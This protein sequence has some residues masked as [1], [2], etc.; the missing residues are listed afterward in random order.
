MEF[1]IAAKPY[2]DYVYQILAAF[3]HVKYD[4]LIFLTIELLQTVIN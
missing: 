3:C 2:A 1:V 4:T